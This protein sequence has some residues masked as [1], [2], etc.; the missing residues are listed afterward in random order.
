MYYIHR[1]LIVAAVASAFLVSQGQAHALIAAPK[2]KGVTKT[3]TTST[4]TSSGFN[5]SK[6][7]GPGG[8]SS[9]NLNVFK[10][11][12][13]TDSKS[14]STPLGSLTNTKSTSD[15][16]QL[17]IGRSNVGGVQTQTISGGRTQTNT[18]SRV[19]TGVFSKLVK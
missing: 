19:G 18:N 10:G 14:I 12:S 4:T 7:S 6:S 1:A 16:K 13:T 11:T 2:G 17:G 5:L 3:S 9:S 15:L 8:V